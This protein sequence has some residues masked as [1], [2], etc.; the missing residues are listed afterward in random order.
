M[1]KLKPTHEEIIRKSHERSRQFGVEKERVFSKKILKGKDVVAILE[2][3]KELI[4][5]AA[6]FARTL[7]NFV[8]GS[9][10]IILLTD[11]EGCILTLLGDPEIVQAAAELN[12]VVGTYLDE[13]SIG[14]NAMGTAINENMPVQVSAMEHFITVYHQWTC[15]AAP[16]HDEEGKIIGTLN[17]TGSKELVHPHT[18][19]LVVAAVNSIENQIKNH[20]NLKRLSGSL[21][22][23]E[24][25]MNTLSFGVI[26][27]DI[28]GTLTNIN[29]KAY[30]LLGYKEGEL[31]GTSLARLLPKWKNLFNLVKTGKQLLDEDLQLITSVKKEVFSVNAYPVYAKDGSFT[32]MVMT[33]RDMKRVYNI[34]NKYTGMNARY[35]FNDLIGESDELKH[36]IEYAKTVS[37]SP[38]TILIQGD[39]G[40][41]K[42]VLAQAIHNNSRRADNGFV[43]LNCGAIPASLMESELFGYDEGAFTGAKKGGHPGKFEL[44]N[45][46]TLFLDEIGDMP[47]EMQVKL[48]RAIQEN[49]IT[50]VGGEKPIPTDVRII[51]A[52]NRNLK[53]E[54][55]KGNFRRD[56]FY[57]LSVIPIFIPP[58][59]DRKEDIPILIRY[60][61]NLKSVK[62]KKN[63]TDIDKK[64]FE[65]LLSYPWP[66]N[67]RELEN[68]IEK[69]VNLEGNL[70]LEPALD[71][72]TTTNETLPSKTKPSPQKKYLLSLSQIEEITIRDVLL[73]LNNNL[74]QAAKILGI[75]R[76]ALYQKIKK[77][78][79]TLK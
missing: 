20:N 36:I 41:G 5:I 61:L 14:T 28:N 77:Y 56:L 42:E 57:R 13:K 43:A 59:K 27:T 51:A 21:S 69:Y 74:S 48:L 44:A 33:F 52:T 54:I 18:L 67:I 70:Q 23:V 75:S 19:G 30:K 34:V 12:M 65:S 49:V 60:F 6:P 31:N 37:D 62:L 8:E 26:A 7:D 24:T 73:L 11:N 71:T 25:I 17:L 72:P 76:N 45:G 55:E 66:G 58:L 40:T 39:S 78:G 35:T 29:H 53:D 47:M 79:I 68:F 50:R 1:T 46:G 22:F 3:N 63:V 38:S 64:V 32:G 15:S 4:D 16:I 9:G 2:K 10:F